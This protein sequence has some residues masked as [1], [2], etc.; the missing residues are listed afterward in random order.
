MGFFSDLFGGE[1][2][3]AIKEQRRMNREQ[4]EFIKE[5]GEIARDDINRLYPQ[6]I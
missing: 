3:T 4:R 1:S 5:Q 2:D 6:G